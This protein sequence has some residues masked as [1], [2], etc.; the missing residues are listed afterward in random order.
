MQEIRAAQHWVN[1]EGW[2]SVGE[3]LAVD[4]A[5]RTI[6]LRLDWAGVKQKLAQGSGGGNAVSRNVDE[7]VVLK[8]YALESLDPTQRAFNNRV[9]AWA[10]ELVTVYQEVART[11]RSRELPQL[12]TWLCGSA[13]SG[14]STT[15]KTIVQHVR[16]LFQRAGVNATVELTAYTGVAAFNIGFGATTAC[17]CFHVSLKQHGRRSSRER[18]CGN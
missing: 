10:R 11:G 7:D 5:G 8:D 15:L 12:R 6:D 16:L 3:G 17:S 18:L 2:D 4:H 1:Q 13:G 14:K 9:L